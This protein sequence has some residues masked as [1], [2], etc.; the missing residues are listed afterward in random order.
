MYG[1]SI[2][3]LKNF[4]VNSKDNLNYKHYRFRYEVSEE[5]MYFLVLK[6]KIYILNVIYIIR[7]C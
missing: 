1:I 6:L 3:N 4:T 7:Y 2:T 5:I